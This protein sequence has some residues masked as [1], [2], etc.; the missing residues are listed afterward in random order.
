MLGYRS[1]DES[2]RELIF[3]CWWAKP[4]SMI[5][6]ASFREGVK[7]AIP[8]W[9]AFVPVS[10]TLGISAKAHGLHLSEILLMSAL[11]FAAPA[12]FAAMEPLAS[13]KPALQILLTT[14][15]INLRFFVMSAAIAR[16][17]QRVRRATLLFA[18]HFISISTFILPYVHFQKES[19]EHPTEKVEAGGRN[20][21]CFLG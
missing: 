20:L 7:A 15:L 2:R 8:V 13:G 10:F 9:I 6:S 14:F 12:Q 17:F 5:F 3:P 19:Q 16:Y 4:N 1:C 11:V 21:C 18:S